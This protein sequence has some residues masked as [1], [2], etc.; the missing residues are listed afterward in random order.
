MK[1]CIKCESAKSLIEFT[2]NK[3]MND[4]YSKIC[5]EC[6]NLSIRNK[7]LKLKIEKI[8]KGDIKLK[9]CNICNTEKRLSKFNKS[10]KTFLL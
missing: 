4:G 10:N 7:T 5:K 3:K 8:L 6:Y 9:I 2:I 1:K